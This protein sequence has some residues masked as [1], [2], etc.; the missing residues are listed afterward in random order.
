MQTGEAGIEPPIIMISGWYNRLKPPPKVFKID[1]LVTMNIC[2]HFM[3]IY[4]DVQ[5]L[6]NFILKT[7]RYFSLEIFAKNNVASVCL[8]HQI[9][10]LGPELKN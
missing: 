5:I 7:K 9:F 4:S 10:L 1:P 3:T 2:T 6:E 8:R